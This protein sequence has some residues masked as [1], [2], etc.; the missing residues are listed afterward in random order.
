[1]LVDDSGRIEGSVTGGCV[2]GALV[3][4]AS[5]VLGK[6]GSRVVQYGISDQQAADVG[7]MCGGQV[8]LFVHELLPEVREALTAV[9]E[10]LSAGSPVALATVLDGEAAGA[11]LAVTETAVIG[12]LGGIDLL[13]TSVKRDALGFLDQGL[14]TVRRYSAAGEVMGSEIRVYIQGFASRPN[15]VI[16]GAI[17]FSV[18][19]AR[20]AR[21]V[22]YRVTICDARAP[23]TSSS[24]FSD[25]AEVV[26]DWPDRHLASRQLGPRDVVLVFTHDPK[27]DEPALLAALGSA[28]GYIGALGSRRTHRDR[29][30]RLR[31]AGVDDSQLRRISA[32]C[33]L[34]IGA[35]TPAETA[36]SI[37]AEVV[38]RRAGRA[39]EPLT[40][41]SGSIHSP[42]LQPS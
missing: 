35:R 30:R 20:L 8:R 17:D 25:V 14:S 39:G 42:E 27:F 12:G 13:E 18:A 29:L 19:V 40:E 7:L 33:G 2:E 32:P 5:E 41:T 31:E 4:V 15:M 22:G 23:F 26:V 37:L 10:N 34:D 9:S 36:I 16:F 38:A 24:R 6:G 3:E 1:M 21:E 28:A 11:K